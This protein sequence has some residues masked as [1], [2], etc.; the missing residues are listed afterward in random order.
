MD[1]CK[2]NYSRFIRLVFCIALIEADFL[3]NAQNAATN[4]A[5]KEGQFYLTWGYNRAFYKPSDI[6]FQGDGYDFTL[7]QA[8]AEDM[9]EKFS[10]IYFDLSQFTVP[11]FQFRLGYYFSK[12]TAV[13]AGWDHMKYHLIPVQL[14]HMSG[15]IDPEKYP[16]TIYSGN[17]TDTP[18]LYTG[19]FMDY[20]HSDG[21]N[22]VRLAIE[23]RLPFWSKYN[24]KITAAMNGSASVGAMI[25]WTDFTFFGTHHR[26]KLHVAGYGASLSA[27]FRF[28]FLHYLFL[29]LSAQAGWCNMPDIMLEDHLP[30]RASQKITFLERSW[31]IGGYIPF[32]KKGNDIRVD[33]L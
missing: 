22:F 2:M 15:Y 24:G 18:V 10:K 17:F 19:E 30:S 5:H 9:P 27:T 1:I 12:N 29:Q 28:E 33:Q 25:P 4:L 32:R 16:S 31:S 3:A 11:Q 14:L 6:H 26:N 7:I 21:F 23:Q 8:R 20:H 13:S